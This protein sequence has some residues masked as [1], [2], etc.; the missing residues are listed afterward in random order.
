MPKTAKKSGGKKPAPPGKSYSSARICCLIAQ[1]LLAAVLQQ[2]RPADRILRAMLRQNRVSGDRDRLLIR[3]TVF[4]LF[5]WWGWLHEL[6]PARFAQAQGQG[7][8]G[9]APDDGLPGAR[10]DLR[11]WGPLLLAAQYLEWDVP[12]ETAHAFARA[13]VR[14]PGRAKRLWSQNPPS[15]GNERMARLSPLLLGESR[16]GAS[17]RYSELIPEWSHALI[18]CPEPLETLVRWLQ[19]EPPL[20]LRLQAED[21]AGAL[22][23]LREAGLQAEPHPASG[24]RAV[25]VRAGSTSIYRSPPFKRGLVEVQDLSS[26]CIGAVCSPSPGQRWWDACAGAGGKSLLLASRMQGRGKVVA[27]DVRDY[28]LQDLKLRARRGDFQNIEAR[29]WDGRSVD[30]R[31]AS[32]DGVLVDAPCSGSGTWRRNPDGRWGSSLQEVRELCELQLRILRNAARAVRPGGV[33]VYATCSLFR[34]ENEDV[35]EA[36]LQAEEE[37]T[38]EPFPDPLQGDETGGRLRIWPWTADSDG[39]FAA[40]FRRG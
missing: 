8:G 15:A 5:R 3:R 38:L 33:L 14:N 16:P 13:A 7:E 28:K 23:E 9:P 31:R 4:S 25:A 22:H 18:H 26:Q 21:E 30:R 36:F 40:R 19:T 20:W 1:R 37:F 2:G 34:C 24:L 39:M 12:P 10:A 32:F 35:V 11:A 27:S 29:P 17:W 6:A